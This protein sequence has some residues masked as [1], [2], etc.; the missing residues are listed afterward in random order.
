M[1]VYVLKLSQEKYY[2]GKTLN[3]ENRLLEHTQSREKG[4]GWTRKYHPIE[5]LESV[6]NSPFC[7]LQKTLEYMDRYGIENVR[8]AD[9]CQVRLSSEE[10]KQILTLL[11]GEKGL[12][13]NC[14]GN[15]YV[16][17]CPITGFMGNLLWLKNFFKNLCRRQLDFYEELEDKIL[18]FGKYNGLSYESVRKKYPEYV[19]G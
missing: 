10:K 2:V 12:C 1:Y 4:T 11:R 5:I 7:E 3:V 9:F 15:H 14:G 13:Y 8:G 17:Y 16:L 6:P 18:D 19:P